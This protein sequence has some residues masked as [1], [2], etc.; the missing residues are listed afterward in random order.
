MG[1]ENYNPKTLGISDIIENAPYLF[2]GKLEVQGAGASC[3]PCGGKCYGP[4]GPA[5]T[6][7]CRPC[8][9]LEGNTDNGLAKKVE[10]FLDK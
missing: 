1:K 10:D 9:G 5:C 6:G 2:S 7:G 3:G 4:P 8:K